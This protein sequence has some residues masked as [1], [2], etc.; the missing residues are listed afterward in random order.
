MK[1]VHSNISAV[2]M[3]DSQVSA[4]KTEEK[5]PFKYNDYLKDVRMT[6]TQKDYEHREMNEIKQ[7]MKQ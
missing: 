7:I 3:K 4:H 2:Q 1:A 6:R 5:K